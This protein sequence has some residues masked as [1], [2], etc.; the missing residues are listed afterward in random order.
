MLDGGLRVL[1]RL[2]R[3]MM[4]AVSCYVPVPG[5]LAFRLSGL[6]IEGEAE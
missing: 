2:K 1:L 4:E 3:P 5:I 6:L